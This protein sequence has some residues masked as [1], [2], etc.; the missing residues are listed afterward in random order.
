MTLNHSFSDNFAEEQIDN[1]LYDI[2][3]AVRNV[4]FISEMGRRAFFNYAYLVSVELLSSDKMDIVKV[5]FTSQVIVL[6]GYNLQRRFEQL[7]NHALKVIVAKDA[8]YITETDI[9]IGVITSIKL[10]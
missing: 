10:E 9:A 5:Y 6:K 3:C 2:G 4:C 7:M 8:R 1:E